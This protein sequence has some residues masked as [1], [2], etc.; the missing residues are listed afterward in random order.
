[1][2]GDAIK[3]VGLGGAGGDGGQG[4]KEGG[5]GVSVEGVGHFGL[6]ISAIADAETASAG[7]N[8]V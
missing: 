5:G 7:P 1:M 6:C 3:Q 8:S 2:R 4:W